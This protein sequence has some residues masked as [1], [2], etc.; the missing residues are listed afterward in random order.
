MAATTTTIDKILTLIYTSRA[1]E[2]A[3][4]TKNPLLA[5]IPKSGGFSGRSLVHA[6]T[7]QNSNARNA[8]FATAQALAGINGATNDGY[9]GTAVDSGFNVDVNFTVNRVKNY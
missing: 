5:L 3:V 6:I 8:L 1:L 9:G 7:Y 2:N 4:Y